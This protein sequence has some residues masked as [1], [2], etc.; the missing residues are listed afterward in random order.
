MSL[1]IFTTVSNWVSRI[2]ESTGIGISYNI[3][4]IVTSQ[5]P[6]IFFLKRDCS[7]VQVDYRAVMLI[8]NNSRNYLF[9]A[10]KFPS[11]RYAVKS[12]AYQK[13]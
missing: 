3:S 1:F 2:V 8:I 7:I 9:G 10:K 13:L 6:I 11:K 12:A 5:I 4:R